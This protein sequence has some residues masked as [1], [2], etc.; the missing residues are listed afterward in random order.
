MKRITF[1]YKD[2]YTHGKWKTQ[3]CITTSIEKCKEIYGLG[4]DCEYRIL[5]VED[6]D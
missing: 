5:K 4:I 6:I 1:E 3:W 2:Q